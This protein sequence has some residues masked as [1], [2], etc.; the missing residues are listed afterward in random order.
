MKLSVVV[1]AYNEESRIGK[2]L[3]AIDAFL[4]S[5]KFSY[6]IIVVDDGSKDETVKTIALLK[7]KSVRTVS[8]GRNRGKGYAIN[9][10]VKCAHG[11][12]V[13]MTDADNSTP[14]EEFDKL[15]QSKDDCEV[16]IGS[17]Y[18]RGSHIAVRQSVPRIILS[19]LGNVLV[20]LL[21]LPG[22]RDSQCGFKLFSS[23]ATKK[24]FPLQTIWGWGF[25]MELLRIAKEQGYKIKEVPITWYN[26]DQSRIQNARV[27]TKTL[28]ELLAVRRNSF[29]G[30]YL[31][32]RS[33]LG[34]VMR[35]ATVGA[36]GTI[37]DYSVLNFTHLALDLSLY[38]ALTL[39]FATGAVNNYIL[40]S[41]WSFQQRLS[42][43]K[44]GQFLAV[45]LI[46]LVLNNGIVY[47]LTELGSWHYNLSKLVALMIVFFW[48]YGANRFWT[49]NSR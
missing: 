26:D 28:S 45:A 18:R 30:K 43:I 25:D 17:R 42:W 47:L 13:L 11:D 49:F 33:E 5:R 40:N 35:F 19:R 39:G 16:I 31:G 48:N 22:I 1:P 27:F 7:I 29:Q 36:I 38:W 32:R 15:W 21:I 41:M 2:T 20:Q 46:G 3:R 10:G 8:Y 24:I 9:F 6:E 23:G 4:S 37:L 12:W 14:I 44:L 34:I